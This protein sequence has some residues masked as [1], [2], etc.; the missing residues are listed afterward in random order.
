[1]LESLENEELKNEAVQ[2]MD[3]L[4]AEIVKV[5]DLNENYVDWRIIFLKA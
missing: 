3:S 2:R 5:E 4:N 1:M